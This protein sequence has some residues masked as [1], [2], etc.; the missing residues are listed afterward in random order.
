MPEKAHPSPGARRTVEASTS[1]EGIRGKR[2]GKIVMRIAV[3]CEQVIFFVFRNVLL[4]F[5]FI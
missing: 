5:F 2:R 1:E 4:L 3:G